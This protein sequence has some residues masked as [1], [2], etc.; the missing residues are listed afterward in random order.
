MLS[1]RNAGAEERFNGKRYVPQE[2]MSG[3]AD[4]VGGIWL[5]DPQG[6]TTKSLR[7]EFAE[8]AAKLIFE[9]DNGMF[10]AEIGLNSHFSCFTLCGRTYGAV[11]RWRSD[12][13][14]EFEIRCAESAGG[15]K[16][17]FSFSDEKLVIESES[18]LPISGGI[19]DKP[20]TKTEL[21]AE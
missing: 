2:R 8:N 10:E 15:R 13:R 12:S 4:F 3:L 21:K 18:T 16:M 17:I 11:G 7:M 1:M 19:A 5:V 9:Q 14:F 20:Y 6:G